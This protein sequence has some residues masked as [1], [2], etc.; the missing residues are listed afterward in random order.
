MFESI[1]IRRVANGF[2]LTIADTDGEIREYVY[3]TPRKAMRVI[4]QH[5]EASPNTKP[6]E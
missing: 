2:V 5:I 3:D 4:K 1:E 6:T